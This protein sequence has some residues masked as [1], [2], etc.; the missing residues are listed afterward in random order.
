MGVFFPVAGDRRASNL[1]MKLLTGGVFFRAIRR[2][3]CCAHQLLLF[4]LVAVFV[5]FTACAGRLVSRLTREFLFPVA[6]KVTKRACPYLGST[7]RCDFPRSVVAPGVGVQGH[8][9]PHAFRGSCRST[10]YATTPLGLA[11][12]GAGRSQ[13]RSRAEQEQEQEQEQEHVR[14]RVRWLSLHKR[15]HNNSQSPLPPAPIFTTAI[16]LFPAP[17]HLPIHVVITGAA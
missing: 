8:P 11:V 15:D 7:L 4:V 13:A 1:G 3:V 5:F 6:Q 14:I 16:E 12:K 2:R 17:T 10:P 9:W